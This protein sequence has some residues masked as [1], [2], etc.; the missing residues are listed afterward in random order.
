MVQ[1][2]IELDPT[3]FIVLTSKNWRHSSK[4]F[5]CFPQ[6]KE[7]STVLVWIDTSNFWVNCHFNYPSCN[8]VFFKTDTYTVF[9]NDNEIPTSLQL[10]CLDGTSHSLKC[11]GSWMHLNAVNQML[12][13]KSLFYE[14]ASCF[15]LYMIC[16]NGILLCTGLVKW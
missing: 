14:Y 3:D 2:D 16:R 6:K 5:V 15:G 9:P 8:A 7:S 13:V 1:T 12:N 4:C 10:Q 11:N